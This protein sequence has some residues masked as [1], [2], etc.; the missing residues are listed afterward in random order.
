MEINSQNTLTI[1]VVARRSQIHPET[2]RVWERRYALVV[3]GRSDTGRRLYSEA[4]IIKISLVKQLTDAGHPVSALAKL[5]ID[6]LR[7]RLNAPGAEL[8]SKK[9]GKLSKCRVL[10][11]NESLRLRVGRELLQFNDIEIVD[12]AQPDGQLVI[13]KNADPLIMDL[14]TGNEDSLAK[15]QQSLS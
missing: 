6:A 2:L 15:V 12:Q 14:A 13:P 8:L 4:D 5:S 1:G 10:F 9:P 3:P 7:E 11:M